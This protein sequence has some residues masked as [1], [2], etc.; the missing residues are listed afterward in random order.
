M[1]ACT[2]K[3]QLKTILFIIINCITKITA[4]TIISHLKNCFINYYIE[5]FYP[6]NILF[7]ILLVFVFFLQTYCGICFFHILSFYG[8]LLQIIFYIYLLL[9]SLIFLYHF[10]NNLLLYLVSRTCF[11]DNKLIHRNCIHS[12][13]YIIKNFIKHAFYQLN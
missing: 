8:F 4:Y 9:T 11:F 10:H 2:I 6:C 7:D 5:T 12:F 13:L 3:S 1:I